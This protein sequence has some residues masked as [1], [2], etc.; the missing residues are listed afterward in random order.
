MAV[1]PIIIIILIHLEM[2]VKTLL[3][4]IARA[5]MFLVSGTTIEAATGAATV[6]VGPEILSGAQV[7]LLNRTVAVFR[8]TF[9]G[10]SVEER[11]ERAK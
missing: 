3:I 11:A 10:V 8:A 2:T 1:S 6:P 5:I 9:L 7:K 4:S